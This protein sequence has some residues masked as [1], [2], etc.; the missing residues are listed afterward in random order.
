MKI[1]IKVREILKE[2]KKEPTKFVPD[3]NPY[4][5][6]EL[7]DI[8]TDRKMI[9]LLTQVLEQLKVLNHHVTPAKSLG[10]SGTEKWL[11]RSQ[12]AERIHHHLKE[13]LKK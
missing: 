3:E 12:V 2:N 5:R 6:Y 1:K 10:P 9:D 7:E 8:D 4:T 11:S 13:L